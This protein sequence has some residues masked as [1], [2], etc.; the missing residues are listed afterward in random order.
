MLLATWIVAQL[1][2]L[3]C[4]CDSDELAQARARVWP[5][6]TARQPEPRS[7]VRSDLV[8]YVSRGHYNAGYNAYHEIRGVLVGE[9]EVFVKQGSGVYHPEMKSGRHIQFNDD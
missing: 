8:Y 4:I 1:S 2:F 5:Q 3:F 7:L 9:A 6:T